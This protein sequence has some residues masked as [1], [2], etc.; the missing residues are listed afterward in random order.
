MTHEPVLRQLKGVIWAGAAVIALF[1]GGL[2]GWSATAPLAS[3][4]MAPGVVVPDGNRR[5]VQ[6]LEGGIVRTILVKDGSSVHAGDTLLTLDD[7]QARAE[8]ETLQARVDTLAATE[9]RLLAEQQNSTVFAFPGRLVASAAA[10]TS[11]REAMRSQEDLF[12]SRRQVLAERRG[13]LQQRVAE[14]QEEIVGLAAQI[15]AADRQIALIGEEIAD[16]EHLYRAGLERKPRLLALKRA[17]SD[18]EGD[19]GERQAGIARA[20]QA[21]GEATLQIVGLDTAN[22]DEVNGDLAKVRAEL[23]EVG[24]RL[25]ASR[26]VLARTVVTAPIDGT[27]VQLRVHTQGGVV[28]PGAPILDVVPANEE[29]LIDARIAPT[30]IDVV[31]AGLRAQV[32][33][34]A[35]KQRNLPRIH[36]EL[37]QVSADALADEQTG[38]PYFSARVGV[39]RAEIARLAGIA[40]APGMPAEVFV[41]TGEQ[42]ALDYLLRPLYDGVRRAFRES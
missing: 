37:R 34:T 29:L 8:V 35:Y 27:V 3:A 9:A 33:L 19:R 24:Q 16:V 11:A 13:I 6:H 28:K 32:M 12:A 30:D 20:R 2:G 42:T 14:L 26:D 22:R 4:A 17:K 25:A 39:D 1:F 18:I 41:M 5:T 21:I 23:A 36:G 15:A 38:R 40:L 10:S 7:A 31:H